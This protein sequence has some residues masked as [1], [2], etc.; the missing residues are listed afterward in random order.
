MSGLPHIILHTRRL[1]ALSPYRLIALSNRAAFRTELLPLLG[2][3]AF[4]RLR[5]VMVGAESVNDRET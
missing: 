2:D 3:H 5:T 1:I 4:H